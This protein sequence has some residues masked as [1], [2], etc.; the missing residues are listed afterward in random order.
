M[1]GDDWFRRTTWFASDRQA[2][3]DRLGRCRS[4]S[5]RTQALRIQAGIL[6]KEGMHDEAI[7]LLNQL[8]SEHPDDY[9]RGMSY[10]ERA[11]CR[12]ELGDIDEA[13]AD[14]RRALVLQYG[15]CPNVITNAWLDLPW[16]I[17]EQR[18][19]ELFS[20]AVDIL[21]DNEPKKSINFPLTT[22]ICEAVRALVA[23]RQGRKEMA[24]NHARSALAASTQNDSDLRYHPDVGLVTEKYIDSAVHD[25]LIRLATES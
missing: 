11:E 1:A 8:L 23:E 12:R 5:T 17:I 19:F 10:T 2:F 9:F 15:D 21:S 16:L 18:R 6:A 20:E 22:Y 13:I 24:T 25:Q 3:F 7:A 14:Y 4:E